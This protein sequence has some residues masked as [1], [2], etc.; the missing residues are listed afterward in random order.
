M[1][2]ARHSLNAA[3]RPPRAGTAEIPIRGLLEWA[4][5]REQASIEFDEARAEATRYHRAIGMEYILMERA[6]LGCRVD[7]G[8][9]SP[10]HPDAEVVAAALAVLPEGLGGRRMALQMAEL[11]RA[12]Q[13]PDWMPGAA[14]RCIPAGWRRS[15]HGVFAET[16]A[17]ETWRYVS[18][19]R[20]RE[21]DARWCPVIYR[22][23]AA[24]IAA[25]R[26]A[27]LDWWGALLELRSHFQLH[28]G[29]TSWTVSDALPPMT[30]WKESA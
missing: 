12:G 20:A 23:T 22:P 3:P 25:A 6:R 14:P 8:G 4:F 10:C 7:G 18:R 5:Q 26:R 16:E 2:M 30:P 17:C 15:K 9:N 11:A 21:V 28:G 29:L 27:Y 19:G 13:A 1:T 24:Q